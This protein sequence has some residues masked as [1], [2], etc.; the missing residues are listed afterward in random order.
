M[1][2][3]KEAR[4]VEPSLIRVWKTAH[5]AKSGAIDNDDAQKNLSKCVC[6]ILIFC[7]HDF[8]VNY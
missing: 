2:I 5:A 4:G 7:I 6:Q 8:L 3:E 1:Y